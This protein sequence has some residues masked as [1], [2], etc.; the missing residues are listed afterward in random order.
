MKQSDA[1]WAKYAQLSPDFVEIMQRSRIRDDKRPC[2]YKY[3]ISDDDIM[4]MVD[5]MYS[6]S[7]TVPSSN[8][9]GVCKYMRTLCQLHRHAKCY[10]IHG[11]DVH[12]YEVVGGMEIHFSFTIKT[13]KQENGKL[14]CSG[15]FCPTICNL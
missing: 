3:K 2:P 15:S 8:S 12:L 10:H 4:S 7:E 1:Q 6:N 11:N 9:V 13:R 5:S 14:T